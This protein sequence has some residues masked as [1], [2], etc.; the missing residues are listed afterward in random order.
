[1]PRARS[2]LTVLICIALLSIIWMLVEVSA[3]PDR[4]GKYPDSFGTCMYGTRALYELLGRLGVP[5]GRD[6]SP[7]ANYDHGR[8]Y[9]F[10]GFEKDILCREPLYLKKCRDFVYGGGFIV[11][12]PG[13]PTKKIR[14]GD[15]IGSPPFFKEISALEELGLESIR[16]EKVKADLKEPEDNDGFS[17]RYMRSMENY[18]FIETPLQ[19]VFSGIKT[20]GSFARITDHVSGLRIPV[21][22]NYI[23]EFGQVDA[24]GRIYVKDESG[25]ERIVLGHYKLGEGDVIVLGDLRLFVNACM[26]KEDNPVLAAHVFAQP[27]RPLLINEFYHGL[28]VRGKPLWLLLK[29][30]FGWIAVSVVAASAIFL[31]RQACTLGPPLPSTGPGRRS[32]GEYVDAM[33]QFFVK[34]GK[35]GF[36]LNEYLDGYLWALKKHYG[37]S[38]R[39]NSFDQVADALESREAEKAAILRHSARKLETMRGVPAPGNKILKHVKELEKC[40]W[41]T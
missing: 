35:S 1:M 22:L 25:A 16:I 11:V 29:F 14:F 41:K 36:L 10:L 18:G 26:T 8:C 28:T 38:Q 15:T 39:L 37:L 31:W 21:N 3:P 2:V 20:Q 13:M 32:V 19:T 6:Y 33:S 4:D 12:A 9:V 23:H 5:V 17:G 7:P 40:N 24:L 34:A 30:P 27:A